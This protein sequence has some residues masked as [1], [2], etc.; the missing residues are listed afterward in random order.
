MLFL[1][2]QLGDDRYVLDASQVAEVLPLLDLKHI[3]RSPPGLTGVFNYRGTVV[4]VV[5]LCELALNRP[6]QERLSTRIII[7]HYADA[8]GAARLLGLIAERVTEAMRREPGE[9]ASTGVT[10][11]E[12]PYLGAIASDGVGLVQWIDVKT[13]LSDA[14]RDVL[15]REL[16]SVHGSAG[17]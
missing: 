14:I 17:T 12:A 13:L 11:S 3:P 16:E 1:Q 6:A 4:P 7:A 15:Y 8:A 9:F 5:D 2:F 10:L